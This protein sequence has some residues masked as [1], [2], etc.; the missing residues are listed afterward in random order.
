MIFV[1][2][3]TIEVRGGKGGKGII[4]F[5]REKHVPFGGP[6]GGDGGDGG[7]VYLIGDENLMTLQDYRYLRSN[8][9]EDGTMGKGST[10][11]GKGGEDLFIRV[12]V[13]TIIKDHDTKEFIFDIVKHG[14]KYLIAKGGKGGLGNPHFATALNKAP[15]KSTD[16]KDG[17][18]R[19][20]DLELK[21][22]A[23]V[24]LVGHPNAG[25]STFL[26]VISNAKPKIADY[27]FTTLEPNLGIVQKDY[28]SFIIADIPGL[29]EGAANGKGLG[30]QFLKHVE[31]TKVLLFMISLEEEDP[32]QAYKDLKFELSKYSDKMDDKPEF[33]AFTKRD[34]VYNDDKL[35]GKILDTI[36]KMN[37]D[38]DN[39]MFISSVSGYNIE[40]LKYKLWDIIVAEKEEEERLKSDLGI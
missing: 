33:V 40:K 19:A 22:L 29:I 24:G 21:V 30:I 4:A 34:I 10:K 1:D 26:S 13:G 18:Y 5:R 39:Y 36:K 3:V 14:Q 32:F 12:P 7:D 23:D 38:E 15:R 16:G 11:T 6:S 31:R 20:I 17:E 27:P 28:S 25:K 35:E 2:F 8:S 9:A 37:L